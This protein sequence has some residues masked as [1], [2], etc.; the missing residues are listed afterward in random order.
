[1]GCRLAFPWSITATK[2]QSRYRSHRVCVNQFKVGLLISHVVDMVDTTTVNG[3]RQHTMERYGRMTAQAT[4][5]QLIS[6]LPDT[7]SLPLLI[8]PKEAQ[9]LGFGNERSLRRMCAQG[10]IKAVLIGGRWHINTREALKQFG[11]C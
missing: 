2:A 10:R 8:S 3:T 1:M 4:E 11:I 7:E 5:M 9:Q 6:K